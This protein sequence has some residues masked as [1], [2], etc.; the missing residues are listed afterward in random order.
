MLQQP[1]TSF[2][3]QREAAVLLVGDPRVPERAPVLLEE[4][5]LGHTPGPVHGGAGAPA[6]TGSVQT[7]SR[8]RPHHNGVRGQGSGSEVD[9][10]QNLLRDPGSARPPGSER[11]E[12]SDRH[13]VQ[14]MFEEEAEL[15]VITKRIK[16][17][18]CS[19]HLIVTTE[20]KDKMAD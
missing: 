14:R 8:G 15:H 16:S 17:Q 5:L 4:G 13:L 1:V 3:G 20:E 7:G 18:V 6:A 12:L 9:Q 19:S 2:T 10:N 11:E